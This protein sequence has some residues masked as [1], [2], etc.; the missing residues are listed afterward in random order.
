VVRRGA[1]IVFALFALVWALACA[2]QDWLVV[3]GLVAH[4]KGTYCNNRITRGAGLEHATGS[5]RLAVGFYDNSNCRNSN[6]AA[7]AWLPLQFTDWR[8][9]VI[10]GAATGYRASVT[11]AGGLAAS[12]ETE[13]YGLNVIGIP[14]MGESSPGVIWLQAKFRWR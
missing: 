4:L 8:V 10:S 6:Y 3:N 11:P 9:G 5:V 14:P 7:A 12:Y 1:L 2:A 13:K